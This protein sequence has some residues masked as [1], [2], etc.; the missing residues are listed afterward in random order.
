MS[1]LTQRPLIRTTVQQYERH[2]TLPGIT[3]VCCEVFYRSISSSRPNGLYTSPPRSDGINIYP[4][5]NAVPF[6]SQLTWNQSQLTSK[7]ES[8]VLKGLN[9]VSSESVSSATRVKRAG[10]VTML[11]ACRTPICS[12]EKASLPR[13]KSPGAASGGRRSLFIDAIIS[14]PHSPK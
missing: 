14:P 10:L 5:R 1:N 6:R 8:A 9:Q 13:H 11:R 2:K 7:K 12:T 3:Y 4:L